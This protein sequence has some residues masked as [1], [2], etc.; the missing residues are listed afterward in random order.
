MRM[1]LDQHS[2]EKVTIIYSDGVW[3]MMWNRGAHTFHGD[4]LDFAR[5][6]RKIKAFDSNS[7]P[8]SFRDETYIEMARKIKAGLDNY[9]WVW[10]FNLKLLKEM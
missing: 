2:L 3:S 4:E 10:Q 5:L 9:I 6:L 8:K 1:I 7:S